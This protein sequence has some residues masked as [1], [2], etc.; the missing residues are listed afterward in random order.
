M[1]HAMLQKG[2]DNVECNGRELL[3]IADSVEVWRGHYL[4]PLMLFRESRMT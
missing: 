1:L 2:P 3:N 4:Y